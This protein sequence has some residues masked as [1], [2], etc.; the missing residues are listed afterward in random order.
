[1]RPSHYKSGDGNDTRPPSDLYYKLTY[2][3][4]IDS[5]TNDH[6]NIQCKHKPEKRTKWYQGE[7]GEPN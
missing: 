1:M 3:E 7:G 4:H 5:L 6:L 2:I